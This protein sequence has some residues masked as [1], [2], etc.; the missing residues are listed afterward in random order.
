M[1]DRSSI[2]PVYAIVLILVLIG[3]AGGIER[4]DVP[5]YANPA[6][7]NAQEISAQFFPN[8]EP[9]V[10][11]R[12]QVVQGTKASR[13]DAHGHHAPSAA[14]G[15][16]SLRTADLQPTPNAEPEATLPD[17]ASAERVLQCSVINL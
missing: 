1:S 2:P 8:D 3:I 17:T 16:I 4:S 6:S 12:C 5:L 9:S 15:L 7:E 14:V 13:P 11:L 10:L